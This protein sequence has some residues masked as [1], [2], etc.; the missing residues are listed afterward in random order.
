MTQKHQSQ[1]RQASGQAP[2]HL[3]RRFAEQSRRGWPWWLCGIGALT[4]ILTLTLLPLAAMLL[5]AGAL[6]WDAVFGSTYVQRVIKFTLF[7]AT[8][9]TLLSIAFALMV[10]L[11]IAHKP[12]FYGRTILVTL[13]TLSMVIPTIAAV[14]GIVAAY[15]R[16]G[17][18]SEIVQPILGERYSFYG[19]T[20]ILIAHVFFNM[21]LAARIFLGNLENIPEQ[22][23]R[24]AR[25][26]GMQP[27]SVLRYI[28]WPVLKNLI[29]G[30]AI[31]I[32]TLCFTSFAIV[33]T[34]GGGPRATTIEV[35]IFQALRFD[36]DIS[37]AVSLA[38]VQLSICLLLTL[39]STA[40][41][42]NNDLG[43]ESASSAKHALIG[44]THSRNTK[45][46]SHEQ[47]WKTPALNTMHWAAIMLAS[48]FILL[49][50]LALATSAINSKTLTVLTDSL[51]ISATINTLVASLAASLMAMLLAL[52]LLISTRHLRIRLKRERSGQWLQMSG[53][54]ILILPPLVL[55][56]GL[57]LLLRNVA[58][59]FSIALFLV[60]VI[61]SLMAVPFILRIMDAPI[62]RSAAKHDKLI[63][64]L[65]LQGFSRW[66]WIDWPQLRRP[67]GL[68]FAVSATLSAGD[69]SAIALFGSERVT[70]LPLLLYQRIGSYRLE[71]AAVTAGLLLALCLLIF[72]SLQR[73]IGGR[74]NA[75]A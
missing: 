59:V 25:Q 33:M 1:T 64:S 52:G 22:N 75:Q 24:L 57:F 18:L 53:N 3:H 48:S 40:F 63:L 20:A 21:P 11:A 34:L 42:H 7:Q 9:S 39:L 13:F 17:W 67:L 26:L 16:T 19:F 44:V 72:L 31:L 70:T 36:F 71:E 4:V 15:G 56:T 30:I 55:G 29:P 47:I 69:L 35:A 12:R 54:I 43:F 14:Y 62:I 73:I 49:P 50:L 37:M 74:Y 68:A 27:L 61:N 51:T 5:Q 45:V 41:K 6:N 46:F 32:F 23:W 2:G 28:E 66:R 10:A 60:I 38:C 58:D 65:G 8:I